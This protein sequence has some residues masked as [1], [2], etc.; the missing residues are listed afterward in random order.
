MTPHHFFFLASAALRPALYSCS[1]RSSSHRPAIN[2][3]DV[4]FQTYAISR[5]MSSAS[6][7]IFTKM[8]SRFLAS[9]DFVSGLPMT[10][11]GTSVA[12]M[13]QVYIWLFALAR[14]IIPGY[15]Y[16]RDNVYKNLTPSK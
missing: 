2:S 8:R 9:G 3:I 12:I 7:V 13:A 11:E 6:L 15:I 10:I 14:D 4:R 5:S 16:K 1:M